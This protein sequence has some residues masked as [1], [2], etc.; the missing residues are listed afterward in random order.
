MLLCAACPADGSAARAQDGE[1]QLFAVMPPR[2]LPSPS[3][4]AIRIVQVT[5]QAS[6]P[7]QIA[8]S[9]SGGWLFG[10]RAEAIDLL[11]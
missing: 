5:Q 6:L 1:S 11:C 3:A 10:F 8:R 4:A 9:S 7:S 2:A